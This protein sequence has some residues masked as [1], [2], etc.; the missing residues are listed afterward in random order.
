MD[1][2]LAYVRVAGDATNEDDDGVQGIYQIELRLMRAINVD[3][4]T[5]S[6]QSEIVDYALD[7]F[8][9]KQGIEDPEDFTI[10]VYLANGTEIF[11]EDHVPPADLVN[12][13][14]YHGSLNTE[15][16]PFA[17]SMENSH[18]DD[19]N[20]WSVITV[21]TEAVFSDA[22]APLSAL[23]ATLCEKENA[24]ASLLL[25]LP[26][27]TVVVEGTAAWFLYLA[28]DSDVP[29]A[30]LY[31]ACYEDGALTNTMSRFDIALDGV[32]VDEEM[33]T[34]QIRTIESAM[35]TF[36][37]VTVKDIELSE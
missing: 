13:A 28:P 37:T 2:L 25:P 16:L 19:A 33:L 12:R 5:L 6:E 15:D 31:N 18:S 21:N 8:H 14:L 35:A 20:Q 7:C 29:G 11:E 27:G 3:R 24:L 32:T 17:L 9:D 1:T 22:P 36:K 30:I 10:S 23:W 26:V 4:M 34:Q